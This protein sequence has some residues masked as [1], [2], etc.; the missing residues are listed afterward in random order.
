M[1]CFASDRTS[2]FDLNPLNEKHIDD[3]KY[4]LQPGKPWTTW[5]KHSIVY[6]RFRGLG[7]QRKCNYNTFD[8][9]CKIKCKATLQL[10]LIR[11]IDT[12][13]TKHVLL[14]LHLRRLWMRWDEVN[15]WTGDIDNLWNKLVAL[16]SSSVTET[17]TEADWTLM[18]AGLKKVLWIYSQSSNQT[19]PFLFQ[20]I[21][22]DKEHN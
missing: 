2:Y 12:G 1:R 11:I 17:C 3:W 21:L 19:T 16:S 5:A 13:H 4:Q 20:P 15:V 6:T 9:K 18:E 7:I 14:I 8:S 22:P 10:I